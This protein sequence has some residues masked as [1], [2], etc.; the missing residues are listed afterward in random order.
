[1]T[2]RSVFFGLALALPMAAGLASGAQAANCA[3]GQTICVD[4]SAVN[5]STALKR[6]AV[7]SDGVQHNGVNR[8]GSGERISGTGALLQDPGR[9]GL[10][11]TRRYLRKG[12]LIY[13]INSETG[14]PDRLAGEV[15]SDP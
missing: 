15:Q 8:V 7:W 12:R 13:Q 1:M 10:D 5:S 9:Y 4:N 3:P 14:L 2:C 6:P 11:P